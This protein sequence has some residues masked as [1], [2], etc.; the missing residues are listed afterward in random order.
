MKEQVMGQFRANTQVKLERTLAPVRSIVRQFICVDEGGTVLALP[1]SLLLR[2]LIHQLRQAGLHVEIGRKPEPKYIEQWKASVGMPTLY[3]RW[4]QHTLL[5]LSDESD[6]RISMEDRASVARIRQSDDDVW[7][8]W[9]QFKRSL[10]PAVGAHAQLVDTALRAL[11]AILT[12]VRPAIAVFFPGGSFKL[13]EAVYAG[14]AI[15]D[16]FNE[17]TAQSVIAY[18]QERLR[19]DPAD[20]IRILE[21]GAGT[22]ATT[23]HVLGRLAPYQNSIEEYCFTDLSAAFLTHARR[24]YSVLGAGYMSYKI[25][26]IERQPSEQAVDP[27]SYDLVLATN[28]LHATE[29][30]RETLRN[31]KSCLKQQGMLLL[32]E[33]SSNDLFSHLAYALLEGWWRFKDESERMLGSP[34]L[35]A[36]QW[37]QVLCS[38]G[39]QDIQFPALP[40]HHLGQQIVAAL[41]DGCV[42]HKQAASA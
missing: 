28:V 9:D 1:N 39:F 20:R 33:L 40:D 12:G 19:A 7:Q 21:V 3:E 6:H 14:N 42:R 26:D 13:M 29:H 24:R 31:V 17:L 22:G 36:T 2:L 5:I 16:Y 23:T 15:A 37:R 38:E 32:N 4:L 41:S 34:A 30:I 27:G 35:A 10:H 8:D 25:F 18:L 11:P